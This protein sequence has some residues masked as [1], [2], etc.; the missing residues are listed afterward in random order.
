M[1][2][3]AVYEIV[4]RIKQLPVED[5]QLLEELLA[6]LEDESWKQEASKARQQA[7]ERHLDQAAIDQA[8]HRVRY[9]A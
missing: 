1:S 2:A 8:V 6:E 3:T 7:R 9:G 4:D 5:R